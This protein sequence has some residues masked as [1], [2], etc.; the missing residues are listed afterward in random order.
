MSR[1]MRTLAAIAVGAAMCGP[2][3][4]SAQTMP[5]PVNLQ[6]PLILKIL[7][8]DRE[9]L[10]KSKSEL[11]IGILYSAAD[12][13]SVQAKDDVSRILQQ[14]AD[15]TV[16]QLAIRT[17][18]IEY[19]GAG[20]LQATVSASRIGVLYVTPGSAGQLDQILR[21]SRSQRITTAT[22]VPDFVQSGV[23]VGIGVRQEKPQILINLASA[24]SEGSE[25]DASL[26]RIATVVK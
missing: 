22:G 2:R 9:L 18:V 11:T 3:V 21:V 20:D 26:L 4:V 25:F 8:Y 19:K 1:A 13:S 14:L 15:K 16:R 12:P 5:I 7:T 6:I 17:V 10:Q 23:A 24:K